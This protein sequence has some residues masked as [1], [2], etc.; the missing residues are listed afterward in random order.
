[1]FKHNIKHLSCFALLCFT[2]FF[3]SPPHNP[4]C[5]NQYVSIMQTATIIHLGPKPP[6]TSIS[7]TFSWRRLSLPLH[8]HGFYVS[9]T[10]IT[11][12]SKFV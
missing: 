12:A 9:P 2:S 6:L 3:I 8:N 1:I 10:T 11:F 4:T 7:S 5:I